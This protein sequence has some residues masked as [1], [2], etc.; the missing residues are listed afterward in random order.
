MSVKD[1]RVD[2]GVQSYDMVTVSRQSA[3]TTRF[4]LSIADKPFGVVQLKT[5]IDQSPCDGW[6]HVG[7]LRYNGAVIP[8]DNLKPGYTLIGG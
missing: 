3:D 5:Y 8:F 4:Y 6:T 7:E 2:Y 1:I